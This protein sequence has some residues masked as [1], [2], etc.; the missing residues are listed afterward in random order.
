MEK[1]RSEKSRIERQGYYSFFAGGPRVSKEEYE[2]K[3]RKAASSTA[4]SSS[5]TASSS[6]N[7]WCATKYS[8]SKTS[9]YSCTQ[10][11]G[12]AFD[13]YS[14]ALAE[15]KRLSKSSSSYSSTTSTLSSGKVWCAHSGGVAAAFP[16]TCK[17]W[18][19]KAYKQ[20]YLAE[21]NII[22][23]FW[24]KCGNRIKN[25]KNSLIYLQSG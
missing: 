20:K 23:P 19:G 2:N 8:V 9:R 14:S 6:S 15:K 5:S 10:N 24:V 13:T 16:V 18:D 17:A 1:K 21:S 11:K 4:S 12:K 22:I 3:R 25:L 7:I